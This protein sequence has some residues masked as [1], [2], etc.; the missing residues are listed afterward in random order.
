M[1][2]IKSGRFRREESMEID[3]VCGRRKEKVVEKV[4][5]AAGSRNRRNSTIT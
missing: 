2:D 4:K 5:A 1:V 3:D